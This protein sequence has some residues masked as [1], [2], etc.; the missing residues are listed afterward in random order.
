MVANFIYQDLH[1]APFESVTIRPGD[2]FSG[3]VSFGDFPAH[4]DPP[5]FDFVDDDDANREFAGFTQRELE[6]LLCVS[7]AGEAATFPETGLAIS[8]HAPRKIREITSRRIFV[9]F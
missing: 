9:G 8:T 4:Y 1:L 7:L 5:L 6:A 2:D 3:R